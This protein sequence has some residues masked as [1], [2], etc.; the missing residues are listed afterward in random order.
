M[1]HIFAC[2]IPLLR[3]VRVLSLVV[4]PPLNL[5]PLSIIVS[6]SLFLLRFRSEF[7][8]VTGSCGI[9]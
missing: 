9:R 8:F 3:H 7:L 6:L 4:A 1:L 5:L 2:S